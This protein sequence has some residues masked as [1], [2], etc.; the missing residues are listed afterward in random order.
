VLYFALENKYT[1]NDTAELCI[2]CIDRD[3]DFVYRNTDTYD[4]CMRLCV[5][6]M[7]E[8]DRFWHTES[9]RLQF[10]ESLSED[11]VFKEDYQRLQVL[12]TI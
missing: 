8:S 10:S 2:R 11:F 4:I 3:G 9:G 12:Y 5:K 7:D 1:I 6:G